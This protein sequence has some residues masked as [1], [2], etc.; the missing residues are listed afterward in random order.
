MS[1]IDATEQA[2]I[3]ARLPTPDEAAVL[4]AAHAYC[5]ARQAAFDRAQEG[6]MADY[7]QRA[8]HVEA[9]R[10]RLRQAVLALAPP[11]APG[12]Q[13]GAEMIVLICGSRTWRD[14][15]AIAR[16]L[17]CVEPWPTLVVHGANGYA[18]D[19]R[20]LPADG[21]DEAAA[22]GADCLGGAAAARLGIPVRR[23]PADWDRLG[24]A[25][26][27]RRNRR[28]L[29]EARPDLVLA[30]TERL[31]TSVGTKDLVTEARRRGVPVRVFG[32]GGQ[33][34]TQGG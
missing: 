17:V 3:A 23:F 4:A 19:G 20:A 2:A 13:A 7:R 21:P 22:R 34:V 15:R 5:A 28:M 9:C 18:A 27:P 25:A 10:A 32:A 12:P 24:R 26:G 29:D 33:E 1:Q 8:A 31:Q 16:V 6:T 11:P 30:F 14:D